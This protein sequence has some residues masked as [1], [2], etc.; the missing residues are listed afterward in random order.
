M[1]ETMPT[2]TDTP[3]QRP[4]VLFITVDQWPGHLLGFTGNHT[5]ETPPS[6]ISQDP[7]CIFRMH[8]PPVRSVFR[9]DG[10]S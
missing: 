7:A 1:K 10:A 4:H 8:I 5:I 9:P 3:R 2:S 6:I